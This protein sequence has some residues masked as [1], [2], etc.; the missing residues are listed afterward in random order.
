[1]RE[2]TQT[3]SWMWKKILKYRVMAKQFYRVKLNN[4][5]NTS[6]WFD[7]WSTMGSLMD[8]MGPSGL[9][10]LG[11]QKDATVEEAM[12]KHRRRRHIVLI[13]NQ[14]EDELANLKEKALTGE[15][16][17]LWK[18]KEDNYK[19]KFSSNST[20]DQLRTQGEKCV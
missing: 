15:D 20:W 14:I 4:G 8:I 9:I 11:I 6:F 17:G 2:T 16:I 5:K 3:G 1:M 12:I 19:S 18:Q 10:D 7:S 13:L